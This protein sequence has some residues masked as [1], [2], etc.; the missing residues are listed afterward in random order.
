VARQAGLNGWEL[1]RLLFN[2][3]PEVESRLGIR[4]GKAPLVQA[5]SSEPSAIAT[6]PADSEGSAPS[7]PVFGGSFLFRKL[8]YARD[9]VNR[10]IAMMRAPEHNPTK[11]IE[12]L[13]LAMRETA[14]FKEQ[15]EAHTEEGVTSAYGESGDGGGLMGEGCCKVCGCSIRYGCCPYCDQVR[16][17]SGD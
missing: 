7:L 12:E 10:A 6:V 2:F 9:A 16:T 3:R 1:D 11:L 8:L 14:T 17:S 4:G 15:Y 5:P 13:E